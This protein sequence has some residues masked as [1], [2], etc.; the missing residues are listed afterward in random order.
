MR[1]LVYLLF[2]FLL[3]FSACQTQRG[4]GK[5][6]EE[7][8]VLNDSAVRMALLGDSIE[9]V[10]AIR[11]LDEATA[12][13]PD[14]YIAY[15]NKAA[16]LRKVGQIEG[17]FSAMKEMERIRPRN[18]YTKTMLGAC[19]ER[20][21]KDI[22]RAMLKYEE[23]D[24]LYRVMSDSITPESNTYI[25]LVTS[26]V[27][28]LKLL[29]RQAEADSLLQALSQGYSEDESIGNFAL[30][31]AKILL[32]RPREELLEMVFSSPAVGIP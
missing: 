14:Y 29:G 2:V 28:N 30:E 15:R 11:L 13:D 12:I 4:E 16:F 7:A 18:P 3:P 17:L 5:G 26:R 9:V 24:R 10:R 25:A 1:K 32:D 8:I 23:A 20:Y 6:R 19:Y 31:E 22:R 27:G 21:S